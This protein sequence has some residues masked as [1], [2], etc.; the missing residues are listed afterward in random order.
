[1]GKCNGEIWKVL[2]AYNEGEPAF[3][4]STEAMILGLRVVDVAYA[5]G[6]R[7]VCF[8]ERQDRLPI[9]KEPTAGEKKLLGC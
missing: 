2:A 3:D 9:I 5:L 6:K 7:R 8:D 4:R 1:M